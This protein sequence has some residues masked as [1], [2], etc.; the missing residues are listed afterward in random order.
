MAIE[1]RTI[2]RSF[3][4]KAWCDNLEA[5]SDYEN[6]L[7]RGRTYVRN[8]PVVDLQIEQGKV[9][10][11]VSGTDIYHVDIGVQPLAPGLWQG[12]LGECAGKIGSLV[13][14]L[15]GRL[16]NAVMEV[17]TRR[18]AGLFPTPRQ[19]SFAAPARTAPI[20]ASTWPP[21]F[22]AWAPASTASR[23]CCSCCA[24]W[25]RRS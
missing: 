24:K 10:A 22:T 1:G 3:W 12:V 6:R 8:G 5:Y 18:G 9:G 4:G 11:L 13:E 19:I 17:V 23:S 20:C 21:R 14:L 16:S 25:T 7:P 15:Q 2:A